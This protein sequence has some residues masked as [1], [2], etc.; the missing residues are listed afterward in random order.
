MTTQNFR[1]IAWTSE[2]KDG[3]RKV[4]YELLKET[5][6]DIWKPL[7]TSD[8]L[9]EVRKALLSHAPNT[10]WLVQLIWQSTSQA[11]RELISSGSASAVSG[12]RAN[13]Q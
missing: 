5:E 13:W 3:S 6:T 4:N 7:A 1:I 9:A 8:T 2:F 10:G 12:P 11:N